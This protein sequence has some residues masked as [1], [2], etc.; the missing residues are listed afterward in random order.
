VPL[1]V[2]Q[3][4]ILVKPSADLGDLAPNEGEPTVVEWHWYYHLPSFAGWAFILALLVLL[5]E[6]RNIQAWT[7]LIPYFLLGEIVGYWLEHGLSAQPF[8][9]YAFRWILTVWTVLWIM[10]PRLTRPRAWV[11]FLRTLGGVVLFG[12]VAIFGLILEDGGDF[13]HLFAGQMLLGIVIVYGLLTFSL[14]FAL[15]MSKLCCRRKYRPVRF[16]LW[17]GFWLIFGM[18]LFASVLQYVSMPGDL[19]SNTLLILLMR[20]FFVA[21]IVA[22]IIYILNIPFMIVLLRCPL[23]RER[24]QKMFALSEVVPPSEDACAMDAEA[25]YAGGGEAL[26]DRTT[27]N[28]T[29]TKE[30]PTPPKIDS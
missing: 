23:Y 27:P 14:L 7:M 12:A 30:E 20:A 3:G 21:S 2:L 5:K 9:V 24:F 1:T 6:N 8:S 22:S 28:S 13:T 19:P 10:S 15:G 11:T 29:N 4:P 18:A 16:W 26:A 17:F 25:E